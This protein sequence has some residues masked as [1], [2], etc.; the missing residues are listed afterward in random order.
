MGIY[1]IVLGGGI[2]KKATPRMFALGGEGS[3]SKIESST[4]SAC[5]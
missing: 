1:R 3:A 5:A 4:Y 2:L